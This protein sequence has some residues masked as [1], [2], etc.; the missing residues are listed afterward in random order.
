MIVSVQIVFS[1]D[2]FCLLKC[3]ENLE[4]MSFRI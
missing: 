1:R 4:K 3:L 2:S